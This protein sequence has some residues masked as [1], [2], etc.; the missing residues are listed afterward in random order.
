[1]NQTDLVAVFN[2]LTDLSWLYCHSGFEG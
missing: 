1:M 2:W